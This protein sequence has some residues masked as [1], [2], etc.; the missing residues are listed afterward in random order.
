MHAEFWHER[1]ESDQ[2]GFHEGAVNPLLVTLDYDRA[3]MPGLPFSVGSGKIRELY[4]DRKPALLASQQ[5]P[6]GLKGKCPATE[7]VWRCR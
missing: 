4:R 6:G 5:L 3:R 2:T 1:W 7:N